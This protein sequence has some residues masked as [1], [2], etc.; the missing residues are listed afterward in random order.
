MSSRRD[1][2]ARRAAGLFARKGYHGTSVGDLAAAMGV[3]KGSLYSHMASKQD[4]LYA[5]MLEGARAFH[6][7]LDALDERLPASERIRLALRGHLRVVSEQLDV[8]TA[9]VQ[10]WRHLE[11]AERQRIEA[12]R[13]R[14]EQ[15]IV[16]LFR[17]AREHGELRADADDRTAALLFLSAANWAYAWLEPGR[18]TAGIADRLHALLLDGLRGYASPS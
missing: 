13:R 8:A 15:R 16:A 7:A 18:D 17:E 11:G 12:E 10:E 6:G 9:F 2:L 14:Y 3:R 5:T 4:L 1:E